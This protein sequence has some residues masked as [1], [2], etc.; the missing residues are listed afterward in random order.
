M[1]VR[2]CSKC[3]KTGGKCSK[4]GGQMFENIGV[5]VRKSNKCSKTLFRTHHNYITIRDRTHPENSHKTLLLNNKQLQRIISNQQPNTDIYINKYPSD[6]LINTIILDFDSEH[7]LQDALDDIKNCALLVEDEKHLDTAIVESGSKG[8]HLYIRIP[9]T[10]FKGYGTPTTTKNIF[11]KFIANIIGGTKQYQTL[12]K[13][14]FSSGLKGNIRVVG[15]THPATGHKCTLLEGYNGWKL[16]TDY[17]H[18]CLVT[19]VE[20]GKEK[21]KERKEQLKTIKTLKNDYD[22]DYIKDNDLRELFPMIFGG[23]IRH[24]NNYSI[25][26]CPFHHDT[27]PSL[28]VGK[29]WFKCKGCNTKGNIW[30]LIK[31]G[32]VKREEI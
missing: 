30:Y 17:V 15:S 13:I 2:K 31:N 7:N 20:Y 8:Y 27:H 14:N 12:D 25:M 10:D 26:Q 19:A 21:E 1:D 6:K 23:E 24:F 3:S 9:L 5:N 11:N 32:Y 16:N 29:E 18:E 22:R 4:M 28:M